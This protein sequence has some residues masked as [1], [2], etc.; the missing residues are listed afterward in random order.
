VETRKTLGKEAGMHDTDDRKE[1][2]LQKCGSFNTAAQAVSD[3]LFDDSEF[4]DSRDL[5]LVKYEML[6]R[7]QVDGMSAVEAAK[8]FGFS[9]SGFY[10]VLWAFQRRGLVGLIPS[11][12]G[13]RRAHKLTDEILE[14][15]DGRIA[16]AGK[17]SASE[18]ARWLREEC[19]VRVHPRSIERALTR[20]EKKGR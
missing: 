1:Q 18:L 10:K 5:V 2:N 4:F 7:V 3:P 19:A 15:V 6:R 9:R 11:R 8:R 16:V 12:P 13:P 20:R 17:L 14:F